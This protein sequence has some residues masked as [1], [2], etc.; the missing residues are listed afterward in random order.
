M[1]KWLLES[2]FLSRRSR[3]RLGPSCFDA[4][5]VDKTVGDEAAGLFE[6]L[7]VF[8]L[9]PDAVMGGRMADLLFK[10][11]AEGADAFKTYVIAD[12][13]NGKIVACQGFPG[14][15]DPFAGEI[16]MRCYPVDPGK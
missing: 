10:K 11:R 16:L 7:L 8:L 5:V 6:R 12:L 14:L 15:F 13:G 9:C 1:R 2:C 3:R 4:A